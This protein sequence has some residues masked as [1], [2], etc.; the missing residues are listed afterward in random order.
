MHAESDSCRQ[1]H[2]MR[3]QASWYQRLLTRGIMQ[4]S[5]F[6]RT[7]SL[8]HHTGVGRN[9]RPELSGL[10]GDRAS[11]STALHLT[12]RVDNHTRVVLDVQV[13]GAGVVAAVHDGADWQT[14]RHLQL[15]TGGRTT[16]GRHFDGVLT[17]SVGRVVW[18]RCREDE[19]GGR[20]PC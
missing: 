20:S 6:P 1:C 11:D 13:T 5:D 19:S 18:L 16:T 8:H 9:T 4:S 3:E 2:V 14:K 7:P 17:V 12:L 15:V 10:L